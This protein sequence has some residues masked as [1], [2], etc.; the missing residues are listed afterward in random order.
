MASSM[1]YIQKFSQRFTSI[2]SRKKKILG[3]NKKGL[4]SGG[5][6]VVASVI[7]N[8]LNL[9]FNTYLGRTVDLSHYSLISLINGFIYLLVI[10]FGSLNSSVNFRTGF[11]GGRYGAHAADMFW[12]KTRKASFK[13]SLVLITLW[14][15]SSS[16]LAHYF[17]TPSLIPYF[18]FAPLLI[19]SFLSAVDKGFLAGKQLFSTLAILTVLDPLL[20]FTFAFSLVYLKREE[21]IY[22]S[23]P[24]ATFIAFFVSWYFARKASHAKKKKVAANE[25]MF[26]PKKFYAASFISGLSTMTFLS[27]DILLATHFLPAKEAGTYALVSLVGKMVYFMSGLSSQFILP[28]VSRKEGLKENSSKTLYLIFLATLGL[29]SSAFL[30]FG[31][32]GTISLPIIF[33]ERATAIL[34]YTLLFSFAMLCF[35]MSRVFV[36]YYLV[37]R[38]F[39][40]PIIA[41]LL[42]ILQIVLIEIN[43]ANVSDIVSAMVVVGISNVILMILLHMNIKYIKIF[44]SKVSRILPF[45]EKTSKEYEKTVLFPRKI[46]T[47]T[48][49]EEVLT[50]KY[51]RPYAYGMYQNT[52]G[53]KAFAKL[54]HGKRKD[55]RYT[56]LHNELQTYKMLWGLVKKNTVIKKIYPQIP[57]P[58]LVGEKQTADTL[59]VLLEYV[60]GELL[61]TKSDRTKMRVYKDLFGFLNTINAHLTPE[62]MKS[63]LQRNITYWIMILPYISLRAFIKNPSAL[64]LIVKANKEIL[65]NLP[66]LLTIKETGFIHRDLANWNVKV[67]KKQFYL[68]DFQLS[69]ISHPLLEPAVSTLKLWENRVFGKEFYHTIVTPKLE[70]KESLDIFHFFAFC[71][72]IYDLGLADGGSSKTAIDFMKFNL[73]NKN[74]KKSRSFDHTLFDN[75]MWHVN[76][77][78]NSPKA[79]LYSYTYSSQSTPNIVDFD[80]KA[81]RYGELLKKKIKRQV[82]NLSVNFVGSAS[83]GIMGEKDVDIVIG[84]KESQMQAMVRKLSTILDEPIK[85]RDYIVEWNFT[86]KD[87]SIEVCLLDKSHPSYIRKIAAYKLLAQN[88]NIRKKYEELKKQSIGKSMREYD[89]EKLHFFNTLRSKWQTL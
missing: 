73:T 36:T 67:H 87:L 8:I 24:T 33:G 35:S 83:L 6:L 86:H 74:I 2:I 21:L 49:I 37:K 15:P 81:K 19:T 44:E 52:T 76:L 55:I 12:R 42:A 23:I 62:D 54:W 85:E 31:V 32:L 29:A 51:P 16:Y 84:C 11:L 89:R 68:Y 88:K 30:V 64:P 27:L 65:S 43:H 56:F 4:I 80:P 57:L 70:E 13:M 9:V 75:F 20:K 18:V 7:A 58:R 1:N 34:P 69:S 71:L 79:Y 28:L 22:A 66:L 50:E 17:N 3:N 5:T 39:T 41:F 72:A 46:G 60:N 38:V 59:V 45:T 63:L 78:M 25:S 47:Y 82:P 61:A 40:F 14:L 10:P 77:F 48:F 53:K 26:F